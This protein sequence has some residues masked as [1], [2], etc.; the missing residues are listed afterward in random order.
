VDLRDA[1]IRLETP[2]HRIT[3]TL[4]VPSEGSR[5]R[6]TDYLNAIDGSFV[7]LSDVEIGKREGGGV[8]ER[9]PFL[10]VSVRHIVIAA[11]AH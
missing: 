6:V 7:A 11:E 8:E 10:A 5:S 4:Q 9:L 2:H 1:R 3:G